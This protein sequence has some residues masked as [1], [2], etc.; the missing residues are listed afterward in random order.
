MQ[1]LVLPPSVVKLFWFGSLAAILAGWFW[2]DRLPSHERAHPL[3]ALEPIQLE[4]TKPSFKTTVNK[5]E[6]TINPKADYVI[7]G[8]VVSRHDSKTFWDYIHT[9]SN[10]HINVADLCIVWGNNLRDDNYKQLDYSS[11]QFVC[12]VKTSSTPV[13]QAFDQTALSNNHLLVDSKALAKKILDARIGDQI[14]LVGWLV[15]YTHQSGFNF[16]RGTSLVRTDTGNGACE[17]IYVSSMQVLRAA[18]AWPLWLM[19]LGGLCLALSSL[20]WLFFT[21]LEND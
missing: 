5:V 12:Y 2:N 18:P 19:R 16:F 6:Y 15:E 11:G 10:D 1:W 8:V 21:K 20:G 9:A 3:T 7:R 17:T 13:W 14:E 4:T